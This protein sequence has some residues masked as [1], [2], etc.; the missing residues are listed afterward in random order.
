VNDSNNNNNKKQ[1]TAIVILPKTLKAS[2]LERVEALSTTQV[3]G[4]A[5]GFTKKLLSSTIDIEVKKG[6][7]KN[8]PIT[9]CFNV[10]KRRLPSSSASQQRHKSQP[11]GGCRHVFHFIFSNFKKE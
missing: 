8:Q 1:S 2:E 10:D 6:V 7:K 4:M 3:D 11:A 5:P 9:L